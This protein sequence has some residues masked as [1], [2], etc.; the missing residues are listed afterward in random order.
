M[1]LISEQ[2]FTFTPLSKFLQ[3]QLLTEQM[4]SKQRLWSKVRQTGGHENQA[5]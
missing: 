5:A 3:A 1:A 2:E 4:K